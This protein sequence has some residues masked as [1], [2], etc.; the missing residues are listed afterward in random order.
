MTEESICM[1]C[2]ELVRVKV[3]RGV[4]GKDEEIKALADAMWEAQE[5]S[6][7]QLLKH[8]QWHLPYVLREERESNYSYSILKNVSAARC[9]RVSYMT[10]NG[11]ISFIEKDLEL[12]EKLV[13]A[14]ILHASP[15]EHQATPDR[16]I[17]TYK[18]IFRWVKYGWEH[19]DL[20]GNFTGWCQNRKFMD[21]ECQ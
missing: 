14:D 16:K 2:A 17:N 15:F 7:P 5:A 12:C 8:G 18:G 13:G 3:K 1:R 19:P 21:G 11:K 9:A 4:D 10:F 6:T 20:H